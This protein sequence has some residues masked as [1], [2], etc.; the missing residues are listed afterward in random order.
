MFYTIYKITNLVNGKVYI[1]KHKTANID[2]GYMGSGKLI[3]RAIAKYGIENFKKEILFIFDNE[4]DM[5]NKEKE[6][7]VVSEQTYNLCPGGQGGF[8]YINS[9]GLAVQHF[10]KDNAADYARK[11]TAI[12]VQR[13]NE[14]AEFAATYSKKISDGVKRHR[15]NNPNH[16]LGRNH[17]EETKNK[18]RKSKNQG[19][20]NPQYGTKWITNGS[21]NRKVK[22]DE[23]IPSGWYN[24]RV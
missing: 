20:S 23:N 9:N 6:L 14:D 17:S 13:V 8:G 11:G 19:P 5:N 24:G 1:G 18:M 16:W 4:L 7:V 3:N 21:K 15:A 22:K 12:R 10:S 2:D